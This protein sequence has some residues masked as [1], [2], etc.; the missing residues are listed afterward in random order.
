MNGLYDKA[1]EKFLTGDID[2]I[3]DNIK[4]YLIDTDEYSVDLATD[5]FL[6]DIPEDAIVATSSNLTSKTATDGVADAENVVFS[7]VTG[8]QSEA[9]V[10]AK[11]T[12]V[13]ST[14][15]LIAYISNATGLPVTPNGGDITVVWDNGSNKIF[16]L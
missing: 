13:A 11:D 12:G 2:W 10:L 6:D 15:P 3:D 9:V 5:E 1:R 16:K 14:S 4:A 8:A 7:T